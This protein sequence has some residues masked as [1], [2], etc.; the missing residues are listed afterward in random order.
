MVNYSDEIL[1]KTF[2]ALASPVR[3]G[4]LARLSQG[5]AAVSELAEPFDVS[6]PAISKHLRI[7]EEAGLIERHKVGRVHY[8]RL[9][10]GP[11]K[12]ATDWL[13]FYRQY[14]ETQLDLL[15]DF[16]QDSEE[17]GETHAE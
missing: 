15:A 14:W 12:T 10:P 11:M 9:V 3:R 1:N 13:N 16:L 4:M 17:R 6:L 8:C 7:M 2:D 5:W